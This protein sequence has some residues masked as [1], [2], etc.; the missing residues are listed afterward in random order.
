[1]Q[2]LTLIQKI[3]LFAPPALLAITL[4]EV[5]HGAMARH[6]GDRTAEMLGRLTI[7]PLKHID[8]IGTVV[9]P[10]ALLVLGSSFLF[11]WAKPVPVATRNLRNPKR[12]MVYVAAAGPAANLLMA[13]GWAIL[14]KIV[15]ELG[16]VS[17]PAFQAVVV[18]ASFGI[19]INVFLAVLN[20][21][22]IPP[23]DGG[24]VASGLLPLRMSS[25]LDRIEPYGFF[26]LLGLMYA[27]VLWPIM[28]PIVKGTNELIMILT[29]L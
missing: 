3:I 26:V 7:N 10:I 8:P 5:A 24:K 12:D 22:P 2:G 4:H 18:M 28:M 14:I 15:S 6:F 1:M 13:L 19:T 23:L 20:M 27:G 11:G 17:Q 16:L 29:G 9:V 25:T 21:L